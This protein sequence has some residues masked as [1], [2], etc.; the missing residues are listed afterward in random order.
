[1]LY[2]IE[3]DKANWLT[4]LAEVLLRDPP[5][6]VRTDRSLCNQNVLAPNLPVG[7]TRHT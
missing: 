5:P 4:L 1:M 2:I 6:Y 7:Y 3:K